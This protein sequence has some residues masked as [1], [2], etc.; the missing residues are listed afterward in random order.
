M[1]GTREDAVLVVELSRYEGRAR[2]R[3]RGDAG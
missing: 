3:R 2:A 1:A